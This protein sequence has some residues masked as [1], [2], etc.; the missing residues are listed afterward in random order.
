MKKIEF[1][2]DVK[3]LQKERFRE[4]SFTTKAGE[5]VNQTLADLV[6]IER[7]EQVVY[8]GDTSKKVKCGFIAEKGKKDDNTNIVGNAFYWV[9]KE[10]TSNYDVAPEDIPF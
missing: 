5:E 6:Y 8:E 7:E 3:K 1:E 4:N 2:V 9:N 10:D